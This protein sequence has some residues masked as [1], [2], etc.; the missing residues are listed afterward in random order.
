MGKQDFS[1]LWNPAHK[2]ILALHEENIKQFII[3]E[4]Y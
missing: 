2:V 1:N 3:Q 4:K